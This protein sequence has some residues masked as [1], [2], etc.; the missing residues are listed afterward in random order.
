MPNKVSS[1]GHETL[2]KPTNVQVWKAVAK[3][4]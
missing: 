1:E 2:K 4:R 3:V